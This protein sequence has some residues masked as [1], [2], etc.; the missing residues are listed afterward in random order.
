MRAPLAG[1][2]AHGPRR[3]MAWPPCE[4]IELSVALPQDARVQC[5]SFAVARG[6]ADVL[7]DGLRLLERARA[8][9][10]LASGIVVGEDP[11]VHQATVV[12]EVEG[13]HSLAEGFAREQ[14]VP[15]IG[16]R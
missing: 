4:R 11:L 12:G 2:V 10:R 7:A 9:T 6:A 5:S 16:D 15:V 3:Q 8:N 14:R 1:S 13:Q